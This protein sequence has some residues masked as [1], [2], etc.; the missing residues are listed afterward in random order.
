MGPKLRYTAASTLVHTRV[1]TAAPWVSDADDARDNRASMDTH[2]Q[3]DIRR[4]REHTQLGYR[5]QCTSH[6]GS[7]LHT[8]VPYE[9][10]QAYLHQAKGKGRDSLR[11]I[12][13]LVRAAT[14]HKVSISNDFHLSD[15]VTNIGFENSET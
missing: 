12:T 13:A 5:L 7:Q 8:G 9:C 3:V 6:T 14:N 2:A 10:T 15:A 4:I 11:M 1:N